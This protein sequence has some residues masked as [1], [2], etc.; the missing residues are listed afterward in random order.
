MITLTILLFSIYLSDSYFV[1][2]MA[3]VHTHANNISNRLY[4]YYIIK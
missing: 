4:L 3:A 1:E 2:Y